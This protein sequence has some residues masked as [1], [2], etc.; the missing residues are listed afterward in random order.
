M[1]ELLPRDDREAKLPK[2]AR[3]LIQR[4][5][6][7]AQEARSEAADLRRATSDQLGT[8][9]VTVERLG[10]KTLHFNNDAHVRFVGNRGS[11]DF[12]DVSLDRYW[13]DVEGRLVVRVYA[14]TSIN[15]RPES[16]NVV[17]VEQRPDR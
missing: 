8:R 10:G 7:I 14:G 9:R 16:S 1:S 12:I 6:Q 15:V 2:W 5:R 13:L 11:Y 4:T 17:T 3:N